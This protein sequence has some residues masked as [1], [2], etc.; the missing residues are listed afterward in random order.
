MTVLAVRH[1][2]E[3][4]AEAD[5]TGSAADLVR[6]A[7]R[8]DY[9]VV[10]AATSGAWSNGQSVGITIELSDAGGQKCSIVKAACSARIR[11]SDFVSRSHLRCEQQVSVHTCSLS[12]WQSGPCL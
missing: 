4:M 8:A 7:A 12:Y 2:S 9:L 6:L 10:T 11:S 5:E 3:E 1:G